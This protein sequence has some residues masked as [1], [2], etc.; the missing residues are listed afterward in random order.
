M[1]TLVD[2][3]G[4]TLQLKNIVKDF[5]ALVVLAKEEKLKRLLTAAAAKFS[6][7]DPLAFGPLTIDQREVRFGDAG[8]LWAEVESFTETPCDEITCAGAV[9]IHKRGK[10]LAWAKPALSDVPNAH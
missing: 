9:K 5:P 10:L 3:A 1:L 4:R 6:S 2:K 8:L 7:G